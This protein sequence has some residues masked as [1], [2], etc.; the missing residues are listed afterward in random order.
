MSRSVCRSASTIEPRQGCEVPPEKASIAAST[1]STPGSA[2]ARTVAAA[3][4]LV[5]WVWKWIG[6]PTSSFS[7]LTSAQAAGGLQQPRHVL[8]AEHMRA[9]VAQL[10]AH[11]DVVLEVVLG[12]AGSKMSPV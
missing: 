3:M 4:P 5:S 6:R 2:A 1:A 10:P 8:E 9:G 11:G 7:A 12:P